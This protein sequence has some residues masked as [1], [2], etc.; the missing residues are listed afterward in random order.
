MTLWVIVS[1]SHFN[2]EKVRHGQKDS[3]RDKEAKVSASKCTL[4]F[5]IDMI[6]I[7]HMNCNQFIEVSGPQ[8]VG[9]DPFW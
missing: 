3:K 9:Y 7:L 4:D 1:Y 6:M 2:W 8:P 5:F